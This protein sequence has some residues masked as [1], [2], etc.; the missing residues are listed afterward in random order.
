MT[1]SQTGKKYMRRNVNTHW[2]PALWFWLWLAHP[3]TPTRHVHTVSRAV[4]MG[5][6]SWDPLFSAALYGPVLV[7]QGTPT[8]FWGHILLLAKSCSPFSSQKRHVLREAI[9][10]LPIRHFHSA[11]YFETDSYNLGI[12]SIKLTE[13][14]KLSYALSTVPST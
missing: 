14:R 6:C 7:K 5:V 1:A 10:C 3:S 11:Q 13:G 4:R 2:P 8:S 9:L 12:I